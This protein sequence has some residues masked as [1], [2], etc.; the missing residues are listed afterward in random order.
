M[1]ETVCVRSRKRTGIREIFDEGSRTVPSSDVGDGARK[2]T[3]EGK[4]RGRGGKR[5]QEV[6]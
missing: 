1:K 5:K 3:I 2:R 4:E 6:D